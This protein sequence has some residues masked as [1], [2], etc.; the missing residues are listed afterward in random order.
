[1]R[2]DKQY[3]QF[4]KDFSDSVNLPLISRNIFYKTLG[5]DLEGKSLLDIACGDGVDLVY[6]KNL[7]AKVSGVDASEELIGIAKSKLPENDI[8]VGLLESLPYE[9]DSFDIVLSKY[10]I[11]TSENIEESLNEISRVA[12]SGALII[13][14]V[15][16]PIRQFLEKKS[17]FRDYYK[18][19]KV[20]SVL[21][22]GDI[23]VE[24][25]SHTFSEYFNKNFLRNIKLISVIE[26]SDF[27]DTSAQQVS[28]DYYPTF[29]ICK[30]IKD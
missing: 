6:Y 19:E 16:H 20:G 10:A 27:S 2:I 14:L 29:M 17:K 1:M 21:F 30:L 24:E 7:G 12:K 13:Y 8:R 28:G 25:P 11:Q 4:A 15:T 22:K 5:T 9:N 3:N 26:G 18:Q 23:V